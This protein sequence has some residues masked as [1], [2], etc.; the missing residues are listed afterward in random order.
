MAD[1]RIERFHAR[2]HQVTPQRSL[3]L[4]RALTTLADGALEAGLE[5]VLTS[6]V[7][8]P[9]AICLPTLRVE[10][11]IGDGPLEAWAGSWAQAVAD[12]V[13]ADLERLGRTDPSAGDLGAP[14]P[15]PAA[16]VVFA[17]QGTALVDLVRRVALGD[18]RHA[19]AWRLCGLVPG[20]GQGEVTPAEVVSA[21]CASPLLVPGVLRV[22]GADLADRVVPPGEVAR[23]GALVA[24]SAG[25]PAHLSG[26]SRSPATVAPAVL[27]AVPPRTRSALRGTDPAGEAATCTAALAVLVA[28]PGRASDPAYVA[29]VAAALTA[30]GG[31]GPAPSAGE[32]APAGPQDTVTL[33]TSQTY[34]HGLSTDPPAPLHP[35][36]EGGERLAAEPNAPEVTSAWGGVWFLAHG[37]AATG[38]AARLASPKA[39]V[40]LVTA[41]TGAEPDD[42]CVRLLCG[43]EELDPDPGD[44]PEEADPFDI[45]AL[46]GWLAALAGGRLDGR[47]PDELWRRR[48]TVHV[49][50]GEIEVRLLLDEVDPDVRGAGLDL[51][52]GWVGWIAASVRF[53]H[54]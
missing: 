18:Q 31:P 33:P 11:T 32:A 29:A 24:V 36:P 7:D 13:R 27:A 42:P 22:V 34:R 23:L 45:E 37:L 6:R 3:E 38:V 20:Q 47:T 5:E 25:V 54:V 39:L 44:G 30:G 21:L 52:P 1:V 35:P 2:Y 26:G 49:Q 53:R 51:D 16:P 10:V 46:A 9:W 8:Q 41:F 17:S 12:A 40:A 19:W 43:Q 48:A 50:P 4:D 28:A 14:T 15:P